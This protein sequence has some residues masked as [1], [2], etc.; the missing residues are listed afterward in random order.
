[1]EDIFKA[2]IVAPPKQEKVAKGQTRVYSVRV[3]AADASRIDELSVRAVA[4]GLRFY[5]GALFRRGLAAEI[6]A[7]EKELAEALAR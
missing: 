6:S 1:M 5:A 4:G 2:V 7:A 3:S